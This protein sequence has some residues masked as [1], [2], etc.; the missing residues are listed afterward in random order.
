MSQ[1]NCQAVQVPVGKMLIC[2]QAEGT[3]MTT[4]L[5]RLPVS[6][7]TL[8]ADLA[9]RAWTGDFLEIIE[10]G[11]TPYKR[12][13]KGRSYWYWQPPTINGSRPSA[14]YL[15]PD[16]PEVRQ[17]IRKRE[18]LAGARKER[19]GIVRA[20]RAARLPV[21]DGLTGRVAAAL[22]GAGAF[23]LRAALV[24]S[25]A[26]LCYGPMLGF[27]VSGSLTRTGDLDI[28]QFHSVSIAVG[29]EIDGDFL[30][31]LRRVDPRF[32][33]IPSASDTRR[34]WRYAIRAGTQETFSVELLAPLR[35]A[36]RPGGLTNLKAMRSD[37]RL[38][39]FLDFLLYREVEAVMLAGPGIP[40]RV[41]APERF[42]LHKVLLS[43]LRAEG[44]ASRAKARKD[45]EQ[46]MALL[47]I[48]A[49][50][51]PQELEAVWE[52]LLDRGPAW[53]TRARQASRAL[54]TDVR[55]LLPALPDRD[56]G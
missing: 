51:R 14:R 4:R 17:R 11:G 37:A 36:E 30:T 55:D 7:H 56:E 35:G 32:E 31:V 22:A 47:R 44:P 10:A 2:L 5:E 38:L 33:A 23:R 18:A 29:D 6:V 9:D 53:R 50:D 43:D 49:Q 34:S 28:A 8:Y 1:G 20:L 16:S 46:A 21:P 24:G 54:P 26:F 52:E 41:P 19:I 45:L 25:A 13:E 27:R 42:A 3:D 40:V 39:R 12:T 15:G 48:L